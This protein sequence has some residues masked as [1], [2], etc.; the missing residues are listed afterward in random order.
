MSRLVFAMELPALNDSVLTAIANGSED[1]MRTCLERYGGLVWSIARRLTR[2]ASEAEDAVQEAFLDIWKSAGKFDETKSAEKTFVTMIARRRI[3]DRLRASKRRIDPS[4]LSTTDE[5]MPSTNASLD[6]EM[7]EEADRARR[8]MAELKDDERRVL[9]L[10]VDHGLTQTEI[11][12]RTG[13]P[14]GTVK[15]HARRGMSRLRDLLGSDTTL[16]RGTTR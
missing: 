10:A 1:A 5:E 14:I 8:M 4:S 2:N 15:T 13:L 3:I 6:L 9:E 12:N 16:E 11:A 7:Q